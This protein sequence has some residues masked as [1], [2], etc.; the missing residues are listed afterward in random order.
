MRGMIKS[1]VHYALF[2]A[3]G[4]GA[5]YA[6]VQGAAWFKS[7]PE[8]GDY[9]AYYPDPSVKV[10]LY[11]T[12]WCPYCAKARAYLKARNV[13]YLDLDVEKQ[14]DARRQFEQLGGNSFPLVLIGNRKIAGF[15][16]DQ[17]DSALN[18][19]TQAR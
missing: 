19:L 1:M 4:L 16:P 5:G 13:A 8:T 12:A 7:R 3:V 9:Q 18:L 6:A 14:P 11:G 10:V 2:L 17:F 15:D